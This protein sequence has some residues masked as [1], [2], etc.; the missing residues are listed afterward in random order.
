M[1]T[2]EKA[3]IQSHGPVFLPLVARV[4]SSVARIQLQEVAFKCCSETMDGCEI[5]FAPRNETT[6]NHCLSIFTG[7]SN[8]PR[9]S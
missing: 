6:G 1:G 9:V 5:H 4:C 2:P 3:A 7:E 8:H